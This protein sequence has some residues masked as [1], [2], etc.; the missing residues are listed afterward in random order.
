MV[1][2]LSWHNSDR[3]RCPL[4][5]RYRGQTVIRLGG[6]FQCM[7]CQTRNGVAG[8]LMTVTPNG[9]SASRMALPIAG[10][11]PTAPA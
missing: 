6:W 8:P 5:S 2:M 11:M 7:A 9:A 10:N 4:S 3:Q 1:N